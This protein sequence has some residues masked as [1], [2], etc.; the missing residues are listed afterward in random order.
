MSAQPWWTPELQFAYRMAVAQWEV[1]VAV[2]NGDEMAAS[3]VR[4]KRMHL[5]AAAVRTERRVESMKLYRELHKT[6]RRYTRKWDGNK[7]KYTVTY[8]PYKLETQL[9]EERRELYQHNY[10]QEKLL[11][12]FCERQSKLPLPTPEPAPKPAPEMGVF[13]APAGWKELEPIAPIV[14]RRAPPLQRNAWTFR[15]AG[16]MIVHTLPEETSQ[17]QCECGQPAVRFTR[18]KFDEKIW[19]CG[20]CYERQ[21]RGNDSGL[22]RD[23]K[24]D[25]RA[26]GT[27]VDDASVA[28]A[29]GILARG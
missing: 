6:R 13:P 11:Q 20:E 3:E 15:K 25:G 7:N 28:T 17:Y 5:R 26:A 24:A 27:D 23:R 12:A 18:G 29:R 1:E 4:R 16:R 2:H 10:Y 19:W 9:S 8:R 21:N 22:Q 14:P